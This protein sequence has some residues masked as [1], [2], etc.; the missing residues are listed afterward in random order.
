MIDSTQIIDLKELNKK[1]SHSLW[2]LH[3][4]I[5]SDSRLIWPFTRDGGTRISE[6]ESKIIFCHHL[7]KSSWFYSIETPT[8]ETYVQ[9]GKTPQSGR[10]DITLYSNRSASARQVN[11]ELK[12]HNPP[13][14][15]I[16]KDLEK[17]VRERLTGAWFHT[18][19][20]STRRT[21]PVLFKKFVEG[22]DALRSNFSETRQEILFGFCDLNHAQLIQGILALDGSSDDRMRSVSDFF[23]DHRSS[24]WDVCDI[25]EY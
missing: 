6:Q 21:M 24:H 1:V 11:M 25:G 17:L 16:R 8:L 20:S 10:I 9:S 22:F 4:N 2:A 18:L 13:P 5:A 19:Q 12:A 23:A 15:N 7:D 3:A 14:E